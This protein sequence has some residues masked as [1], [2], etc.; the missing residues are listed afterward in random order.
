MTSVPR[1]PEP[2]VAAIV[3]AVSAV[4]KLKLPLEN[5]EQLLDIAMLLG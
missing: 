2:L 1:P 5:G 4:E 3:G